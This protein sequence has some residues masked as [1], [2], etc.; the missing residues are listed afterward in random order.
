MGSTWSGS[1]FNQGY[2]YIY[3]FSLLILFNIIRYTSRTFMDKGI[4]ESVMEKAE[5]TPFL[6]PPMTGKI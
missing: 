6:T 2:A 5:T 3:S 4:F 1:Q